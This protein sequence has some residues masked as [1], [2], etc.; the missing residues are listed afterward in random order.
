MTRLPLLLVLLCPL[1]MATDFR[2][3][4][5]AEQAVARSEARVAL[6]I[7]NGAYP[8]GALRNP[9]RDARAV[10]AAL[11]A[12]GF[13]VTLVENAGKQAME[14]AVIDFGRALKQGGVGLFYYAGHGV[15]QDGANYL[16]PVDADL[17][18]DAY[19]RSR[20]VEVGY[21]TAEMEASRNRLNILVL[22]ACRNNPYAA[23]TRSTSRGLATVAGPT[24]TYIA[25]SA[26]A[27]EVAADGS[28]ANS[29]F[30][31]AL[32]AHLPDPG[33]D[34]DAVFN[35][36]R[37]EVY[38]QTERKQT[39]ESRN[40]VVGP[41]FYFTPGDTGDTQ[42]EEP[43]PE[44]SVLEPEPGVIVVTVENGGAVKLDGVSRGDGEGLRRAGAVG[45]E[46][47]AARGERGERAAGGAGEAREPGERGSGGGAACPG[48]GPVAGWDRL[49]GHPWWELLDGVE[50][51]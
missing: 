44:V 22:D 28:G 46:R 25:Y 40:K 14:E 29:P 12:R 15:E 6:V 10:K 7:G 23:Q 18:D 19:I 3:L 37:T 42:V 27:G 17:T 9:V 11:E 33:A 47:R 24:G 35:A 5:A 30:A 32:V 20:T 39:P 49:G 48:G 8:S 45:S 43:E 50:R 34:L 21:V 16:V 26:S 51:G 1:V 2:D 38:G 13:A 36:V 41:S 4:G 31:A